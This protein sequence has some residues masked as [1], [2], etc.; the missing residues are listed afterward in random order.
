MYF[1]GFVGI[2]II[3]ENVIAYLYHIINIYCI[4]IIIIFHI[5]YFILLHFNYY[6]IIKS[7]FIIYWIRL[8][9]MYLDL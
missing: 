7:L 1:K 4:I 6:C 2:F 9:F 5:I 8:A 3:L